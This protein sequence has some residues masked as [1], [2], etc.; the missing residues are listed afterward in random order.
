MSL[1]CVLQDPCRRLEGTMF[2]LPLRND[3]TAQASQIIQE[4]VSDEHIEKLMRDFIH[5][6]K[7]MIMFTRSMKKIKAFYRSRG[8]KTRLLL[9]VTVS[10]TP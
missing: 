7:D 6:A 8:N 10:A 2:R 5:K 4:I 1:F 9:E 3:R